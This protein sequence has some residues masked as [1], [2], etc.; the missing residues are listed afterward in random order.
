M[1]EA[2]AVHLGATPLEKGEVDSPVGAIRV[3]WFQNPNIGSLRAAARA[4]DADDGDWM[5]VRRVTPSTID[6]QLLRAAEVPADPEGRLKALVGAA[7]S[8][9]SVEKALADALGLRGTV[10]HDLSEEREKLSARR[11]GDL[12]ELLDQI[13]P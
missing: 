10:N 2:F 4:L 1:P 6:F 3:S 7:G 5:F 11:E 13:E 9:A 12:V 8:S